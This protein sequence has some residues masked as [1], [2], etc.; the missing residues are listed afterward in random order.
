[1]MI[2][3]ETY[4]EERANYTAVHNALA[5]NQTQF[6]RFMID[7]PD[8]TRIVII[9][10]TSFRR[11]EFSQRRMKYTFVTEQAAVEAAVKFHEAHASTHSRLAK[12]YGC[13]E[14]KV[15]GKNS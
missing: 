5:R 3:A 9:N 15:V 1:M 6:Y 12:K 4:E 7:R 13:G 10:K 11:T 8:D 2:G 14:G